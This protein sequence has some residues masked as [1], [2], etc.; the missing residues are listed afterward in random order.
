MYIF[1]LIVRKIVKLRKKE[2]GFLLETKVQT[3]SYRMISVFIQRSVI[4][5]E[6]KGEIKANEPQKGGKA[7]AGN[8]DM[9]LRV[10]GNYLCLQQLHIDPC[11]CTFPSGSRA[12]DQPQRPPEVNP[13]SGWR[14]PARQQ[15]VLLLPAEL[16][17][18]RHRSPERHPPFRS[19]GSYN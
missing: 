13:S 16:W 15:D 6:I 2:S 1:L 12:R 10:G 17:E 5:R 3:E 14:R 9:K 7:S 8:W 19:D 11:W 4:W 18:W